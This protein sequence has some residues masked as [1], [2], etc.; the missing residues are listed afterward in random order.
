MHVFFCPENRL[1][2]IAAQDDMVIG[3]RIEFTLPR[4]RRSPHQR[5][6]RCSRIY[7]P[8]QRF[9]HRR[10]RHLFFIPDIRNRP[11]QPQN[12]QRRPAAQI[13]FE[14]GRFDPRQLRR[15][16]GHFLLEQFDRHNGI[17][18]IGALAQPLPLACRCH[19]LPQFFGSRRRRLFEH[20]LALQRQH[21]IDAVDN[22]PGDFLHVFQA[23]FIAADAVFL[24]RAVITARARVRRSN[25]IDARRKTVRPF[26]TVDHRESRLQRLPQRVDDAPR[27]MAQFI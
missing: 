19:S 17:R 3:I 25:Q 6:L 8:L 4:H 14:T 12:L 27:E 21:K 15:A 26:D 2:V 22:W 24:P 20:A 18:V 7:F 13:L 11:R 23:H 5:I 9:V 16:E 10:I 1:A